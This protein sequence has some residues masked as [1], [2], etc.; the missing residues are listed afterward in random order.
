METSKL[1][2]FKTQL[3]KE[4]ILFSYE[5]PI[6]QGLLEEIGDVL[7][8]EIKLKGAAQNIIQRIFSIFIEEVQNILKFSYDKGESFEED[9]SLKSGVIIL[10]H[11]DTNYYTICGNIIDSKT[12]DI[13]SDKL[14]ILKSMNKDELCTMYRKRLKEINIETAESAG[15]GLIDIARKS[16]GPLDYYFHD[17]NDDNFFFSLKVIV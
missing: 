3:D 15:L 1:Y 13:L 12:K 11:K 5:G 17:M 8:K 10:G 7:Q 14:A 9:F 4:G 6:T 16:N 2:D